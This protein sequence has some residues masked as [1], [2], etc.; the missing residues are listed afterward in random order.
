MHIV[1]NL[2]CPHFNVNILQLH[3]A[4]NFHNR[5][6]QNIPSISLYLLNFVIWFRLTSLQ[7]LK[8]MSRNNVPSSSNHG[9]GNNRFNPYKRRGGVGMWNNRIPIPREKPTSISIPSY[10]GGPSEPISSSTLRTTSVCPSN[11]Q[12]MI[13]FMLDKTPKNYPG[14]KLYFPLEGNNF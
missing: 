10:S 3:S 8:K 2:C 14:W 12:Q 11:P 4:F 1:Q 5:T 6:K 13:S 7:S 9:G